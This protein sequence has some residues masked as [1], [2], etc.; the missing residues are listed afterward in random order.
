VRFGT[1]KNLFSQNIQNLNNDICDLKTEFWS[2]A[3]L[4][5]GELCGADPPSTSLLQTFKIYNN[6]VGEGVV[7]A[8]FCS[9]LMAPLM[10]FSWLTILKDE[11]FE[12]YFEATSCHGVGFASEDKLYLLNIAE[13]LDCN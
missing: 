5:G 12:R 7:P 3:W 2:K 13:A 9:C 4:K 10:F 11:V 6:F 1:L 8:H